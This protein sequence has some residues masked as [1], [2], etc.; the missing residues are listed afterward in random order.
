MIT[1]DRRPSYEELL[2]ENMRLRAEIA[3]LRRRAGIDPVR[4]ASSP[5][6]NNTG[7]VT[8]HSSPEEKIAF[9]MRLFAGRMD[10]YARRWVSRK[11]GRS[12]YSPVCGNEWIPG[13][14]ERPKV[15]CAVCPNRHL[16]PLAKDAI[17]RHLLGKDPDGGDVVGVYPMLA[18]ETCRSI[19]ADFDDAEWRDDVS[20]FRAVCRENGIDVH[21]ERSR[22]GNGAHAW[23]FFA[24]P[25]SCATARRLFTGLLT[26]A[27]DRRSGI[28]LS[29]Y[30]RLIP[31]QD[32]MPAGGFGNLI[33]LPLQGLARRS[34]NSEFVDDDLIAYHDQWAY[35]S[36]IEPI[37]IDVAERTAD[38]FCAHGELGVLADERTDDAPRIPWERRS[39]PAPLSS[40]DFRGTVEMVRA[41]GLYVPKE[42]CS[43][44]AIGRIKRLA[45]FKNPE[46]FKAQAM[47]MSTAQKS[48][49]IC[50]AEDIDGFIRLPRGLEASLIELVESSGARAVVI[51]KTNSGRSIDVEFLGE[52]RPAQLDAARDMLDHDCGV[53]SATTAFGKT[54]TAAYIIASRRVNTLVLVHTQALMTQWREALERT[55][56]VRADEDACE[57]TLKRKGRPRRSSAI[58]SA[59]E[60]TV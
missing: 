8:R 43:E 33:A 39:A 48:R 31:N 55:L 6:P 41:N 14:C 34:G 12:G 57:T 49:V 13:V 60:R 36:A 42:L 46:F 27:M 26:A 22:S 45:A 21:V 18:D 15:K 17:Y 7:K 30:D 11:S 59:A 54:M 44:R 19:A 51:D 35:L 40:S 28:K 32:T 25:I 3:E 52:L 1:S 56:V 38:I 4:E 53:L 2:A 10:V 16:L 5:A 9:F 47:H 29:S 50:T 58:A 20:A 37:P 24:E 23:A